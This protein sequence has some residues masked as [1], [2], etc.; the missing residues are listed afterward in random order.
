MNSI[1]HLKQEMIDK[2]SQ[3]SLISNKI[4]NNIMKSKL[5][6]NNNE[7]VK[8]LRNSIF[9]NTSNSLTK[10]SLQLATKE[11]VDYNSE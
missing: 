3:G 7:N 10:V 2:L 1:P 8:N 4:K 11:N 6:E 9:N 5:Y